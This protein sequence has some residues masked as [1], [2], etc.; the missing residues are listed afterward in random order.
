MKK[1][2]LL[3]LGLFVL[4]SFVFAAVKSEGGDCSDIR[5]TCS[6]STDGVDDSEMF[7]NGEDCIISAENKN[8]SCSFDGSDYSYQEILVLT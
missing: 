3:I 1:L 8:L 6:V 4:A 7:A 2:L 5:E